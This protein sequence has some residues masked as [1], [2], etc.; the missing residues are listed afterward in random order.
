MRLCIGGRGRPREAGEIKEAANGALKSQSGRN[1][2]E[3][4]GKGKRL[5]QKKVPA[6]ITPRRQSNSKKRREKVDSVREG[7]GEKT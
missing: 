7:E 1:A 5:Q 4:P 2:A 3:S 6:P